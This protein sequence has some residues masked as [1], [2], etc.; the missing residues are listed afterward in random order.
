MTIAPAPARRS[1]FGALAI[2]TATL[3]LVGNAVALIGRTHIYGDE[4]A[5]LMEAALAQ[6]LVTGLVVVPVLLVTAP[7]ASRESVFAHVVSLGALAFLAYNYAIYCFSIEFGSLFLL[8]TSLLGLST[9][10]LLIGLRDAV[11]LDVGQLR[12]TRLAAGTL[13]I[14]SVMFTA[15]W[16]REIVPDLV[17]G[18]VS[19]SAAAWNVPTNP[20]HVLD[21]A[22]FL[23]AAFAAGL[24][25][26]TGRRSGLLLA[27]CM[28]TF[29]ALTS[30]PII[31]TPLVAAARSS[32]P[33]WGAVAPVSAV[34]LVSVGALLSMRRA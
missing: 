31:V 21:L 33:V 19:T 29:F 4:T 10:A 6:D 32:D 30:I 20:V 14:V 8:W 24:W 7:L 5:D 1:A 16:L 28:L 26:L 2:L 22:L 3:A 12:P 15:L 27:P 11:S 13:L 23:P 25:L 9:Y 34:A 18:R 17:H